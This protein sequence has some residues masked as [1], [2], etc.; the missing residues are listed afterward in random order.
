MRRTDLRLPDADLQEDQAIADKILT[1]LASRAPSTSIFPSDVARAL[2]S[3]QRIWRA[4]MPAI[5]RVAGQLAVEGR[6]KVTRGAM[7]VD[8]LSKGGPIRIRRP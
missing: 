5:R 8:A 6:A 4:Q 7:E 1:L 3:D 2:S